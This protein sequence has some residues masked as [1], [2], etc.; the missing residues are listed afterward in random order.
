MTGKNEKYAEAQM[1]IRRPSS[2]VF[3]AF[4]DPSITKNFWFTNGSGRLEVNKRI[5]WEWEMYDVSTTVV[6]KEILPDEKIVFEWDDP[7]KTVELKFQPLTDGS[8]FVT[9]T[10]YG[11]GKS[12]DDLL[13]AIR[14]STGGFTTVLDGLKAF[15]EHG[16]NLNLIAD[17]FPKEVM[18]HGE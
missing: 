4:M 9:A 12:G 6:V 11:N 5:A 13:A 8:T 1:C 16:I 17:K 15:L 14:D 3:E 7:A 18:Q 10:E 2:Q